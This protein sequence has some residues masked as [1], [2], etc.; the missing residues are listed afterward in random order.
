MSPPAASWVQP[1]NH[2][3][4][5]DPRRTDT[6]T[7][8]F[9]PPSLSDA[10]APAPAPGRQLF[11]LTPGT[12]S[13]TP[14]A[15]RLTPRLGG[16]AYAPPASASADIRSLPDVRRGHVGHDGPRR[17]GGTVR[18]GATHL[19][20]SL[21]LSRGGRLHRARR[22]LPSLPLPPLST[23]PWH[24]PARAPPS[25]R[26]AGGSNRAIDGPSRAG[27]DAPSAAESGTSA[28]WARAP[29]SQARSY[30]RVRPRPC[31]CPCRCLPS[32]RGCPNR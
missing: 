2:S 11:S 4:A 10:P 14:A 24:Q 26:G 32:H 8:S 29:R 22:V 5:S 19:L 7:T 9:S 18:L 16:T 1:V 3:P 13:L 30:P 20:G 15:C 17:A 6:S 31:R 25:F 28:R 23:A 21:H 27:H 12:P